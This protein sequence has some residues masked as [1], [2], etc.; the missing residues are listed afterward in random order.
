MGQNIFL[1]YCK[2][3]LFLYCTWLPFCTHSFR[4][5]P[6]KT[7]KWGLSCNNE[8]DTFSFSIDVN[9]LLTLTFVTC[10]TTQIPLKN[11]GR[12]FC[13][14]L[15]MLCMKSDT[16][17]PIISTYLQ[18]I[19]LFLSTVSTSGLWRFLLST[20]IFSW[21]ALF[22]FIFLS[23]AL[24]IITWRFLRRGLRSCRYF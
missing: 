3:F 14:L 15:R 10:T 20:V 22:W 23:A 24:H 4:F 17:N 1:C 16:H 12:Y 21:N 7:N 11:P 2:T 5:Q 6:R 19:S 13:S 9:L 18:Q 8:A